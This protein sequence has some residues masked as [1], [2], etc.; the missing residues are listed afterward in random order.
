MY[1]LHRYTRGRP[2]I[3]SGLRRLRSTGGFDPSLLGSNLKVWYD[4]QDLS[5]M[6]SDFVMTPATIGSAVALQWDKANHGYGSEIRDTG[7]PGLAGT[8]TAATYNT[9]TGEGTAVR[10]DGSNISYI[11]WTS[12]TVGRF[13]VV[14]LENTGS[15]TFSL[16]DG[17]ATTAVS[18]GV[19]T[20]GQRKTIYV[21]AA[22]TNRFEVMGD[23]N[24]TSIAF[25]V[26]SVKEVLGT[27][28]YQSTAAQ[29]PILGRHPKGGRRN[30]T[31]W[32][33]D[34]TNAAWTKAQVDTPAANILV[35]NTAN[36]AHYAAQTHSFE[37]GK[38]YTITAT[39]SELDVGS[40]R[41]LS[42]MFPSA[43]FGSQ[44]RCCIDLATGI[45]TEGSGATGDAVQQ[46]DGS[47][48]F[49]VTSTAT[50]TASSIIYLVISNV[51][52]NGGSTSSRVGDGVSGFEISEF[53]VEQASNASGYQKVTSAY[54]V[55]ETGVPDV[56]YLQADGSDDGMVTPSLD[57]TA[58][59]KIGVF[60]AVR[61][62]SDA[63]RAMIVEFGNSSLQAFRLEGPANIGDIE[64]AFSS[65][66]TLT[67]FAGYNNAA[68]AA[69]N[70]SILTGLGDV[71]G[72]VSILRINGAQ[73]A[74]TT[75]DQGTGNYGDRV[76]YFF[77]RGG[78]SLPFN[79][80]EYGFA[81]CDT[82]PTAG[83]IDAMEA[84]INNIVGAY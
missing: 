80:L 59:D 27:P 12:A 6:F 2:T 28:R 68:G 14:D 72:D 9:S 47:W 77:R 11:A 70:T 62:L 24:A 75:T 78:S 38:T 22:G 74:I 79:G 73:A 63:A 18:G 40:K 1:N 23:T 43:A 83:Q 50:A 34:L 32:T 54:D 71:S 35:E 26:H 20:A 81:R 4:N 69:P 39:A 45:I 16:R 15:A 57:L 56:Y 10:V 29:R 46:P 41:Y 60:T 33:E 21:L 55:T 7:V 61:K 67:G 64:Y 49:S 82:T 48:R 13:Y 37:S 84:Y 53:Q 44:R 5:T 3:G 66:G 65:A 19:L 8:A 25:T 58:T 30:M 31:V 17:N 51:T 52:T 76:L 36:S 42:L